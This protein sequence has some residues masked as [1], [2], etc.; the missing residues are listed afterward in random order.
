MVL[1][2]AEK[3]HDKEILL[4]RHF[5]IMLLLYNAYPVTF[6]LSGHWDELKKF[7]LW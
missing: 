6:V 1:R 7:Y 3:K 2:Q 4:V 5:G